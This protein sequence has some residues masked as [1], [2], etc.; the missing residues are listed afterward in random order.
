MKNMKAS[1]PTEW[2]VGEPFNEY[3][4]AYGTILAHA[5]TGDAAKIAGYC[6]KSEG[7]D[8]IQLQHFHHLRMSKSFRNRMPRVV[9]L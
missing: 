3:A 1:A 9:R 5:H 2:L 8:P 6:G 7:L 4:L